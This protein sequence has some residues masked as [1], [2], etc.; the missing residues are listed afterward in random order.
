MQ[1]NGL[2]DFCALLDWGQLKVKELIFHKDPVFV[3]C[4]LFNF[5]KCRATPAP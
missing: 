4:F 1:P 2:C 3:R 5:S